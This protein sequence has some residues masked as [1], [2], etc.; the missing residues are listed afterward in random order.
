M[1]VH[2]WLCFVSW[3]DDFFFVFCVE[4]I[5]FRY[6]FYMLVRLVTIS[7]KLWYYSNQHR[8][9]DFFFVF[10]RMSFVR[11]EWWCLFFLHISVTFQQRQQQNS[12]IFCYYCCWCWYQIDWITPVLFFCADDTDIFCFARAPV[13][14]PWSH[15]INANLRQKWRT[16]TTITTTRKNRPTICKKSIGNENTNVCIREDF[17]RRLNG[18][19][20]KKG[21]KEKR[22]TE[23][24]ESEKEKENETD[25]K[26]AIMRKL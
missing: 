14:F 22:Q 9:E 17:V 6:E 25:T 7:E 8:R 16:F 19:G 3:C 23:Q 13:I 5:T 12:F 4:M 21:E 1:P 2:K 24:E 20:E 26:N 10:I 18:N 15:I 11:L